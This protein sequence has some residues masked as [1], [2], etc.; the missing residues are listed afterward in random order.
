MVVVAPLIFLVP[1]ERGALSTLYCATGA[2][3]PGGLYDEGPRIRLFLLS[4]W[5]KGR[6]TPDNAT[7]AF[8]AIDQAIQAKGGPA[9]VV[10]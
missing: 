1:V 5:V 9:F 3:E 7:A 2:V 10:P 4:G 6:Y 8:A